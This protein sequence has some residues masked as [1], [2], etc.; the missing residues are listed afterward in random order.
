M[1]RNCYGIR[2]SLLLRI[3]I[4]YKQS[5]CR[6]REESPDHEMQKKKKSEILSI[7]L[8]PKSILRLLLRFNKFKKLQFVW[9]EYLLLPLFIIRCQVL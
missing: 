7:T 8:Q 9:L 5:T 4:Y 2:P 3:R 1:H 6:P